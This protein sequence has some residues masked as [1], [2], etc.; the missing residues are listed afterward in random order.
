MLSIDCMGFRYPSKPS[1]VTLSVF[2]I[3]QPA[4]GPQVITDPFLWLVNM[5]SKTL[6]KIKKLLKKDL[7]VYV[8]HVNKPKYVC[9]SCGRVANEK[10]LLCKAVKIK[11]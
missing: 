10:S 11:A 2:L 3:S 1:C 6:C 9:K 4:V 5:S 8:K 7:D